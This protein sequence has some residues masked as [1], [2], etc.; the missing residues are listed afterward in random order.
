MHLW[1]WSWEAWAWAHGASGAQLPRGPIRAVVEALAAVIDC[2]AKGLIP[3]G[4]KLSADQRCR[5]IHGDF[6]ALASPSAQGFDP[7]SP[8]RQFHAVL[9][10]IDHP[11]PHLLREGHRAFYE[12]AGLGRLASF[13]LA[14]G[15]FPLWSDDTPDGEFQQCRGCSDLIRF[16]TH[17]RQRDHREQSM[18]GDLLARCRSV[19]ATETVDRLECSPADAPAIRASHK[20]FPLPSRLSEAIARHGERVY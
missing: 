7:E 20:R 11:P 5:L 9:P 1:T 8:G 17:A 4:E 15:V 2:H 16:T 19:A 14:G 18:S 12:T 13:L 10:D 3:L 6:F